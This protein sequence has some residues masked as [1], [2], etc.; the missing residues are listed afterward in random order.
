MQKTLFPG[1]YWVHAWACVFGQ[2]LSA[3]CAGA[4]WVRGGSLGSSMGA[5]RPCLAQR[6]GVVCWLSPPCSD[7]DTCG[8]YAGG[9]VGGW[10]TRCLL[11]VWG[12]ACVGAWAGAAAGGSFGAFAPVAV[13]SI[14][15]QVAVCCITWGGGYSTERFLTMRTLK[16]ARSSEHLQVHNDP[17]RSTMPR[18]RLLPAPPHA[19]LRPCLIYA[20]HCASKFYLGSENPHAPFYYI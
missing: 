17:A 14:A 8:R 18:N 4:A 2:F 5:G 6:V 3:G 10:A 16:V 1:T 20:L 11:A 19:S 15:A 9:R 13:C 7:A 12:R